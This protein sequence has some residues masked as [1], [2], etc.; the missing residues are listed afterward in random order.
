MEVGGGRGRATTSRKFLRLVV[1]V[2][3]RSSGTVLAE[4]VADMV[5]EP[6]HAMM[7]IHRALSAGRINSGT[8]SYLYG[9]SQIACDLRHIA[10]RERTGSRRCC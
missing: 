7:L 10:A 8:Q 6:E 2:S 1:R 9:A 3:T 5:I 4:N